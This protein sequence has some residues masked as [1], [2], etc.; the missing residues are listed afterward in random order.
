MDY[1]QQIQELANVARHYQ[2]FLTMDSGPDPIRGKM[3]GNLYDP[4]RSQMVSYREGLLTQFMDIPA[5]ALDWS[6]TRWCLHR[7]DSMGFTMDLLKKDQILFPS[8]EDSGEAL[9][10]ILSIFTEV[11]ED[12]LRSR[13]FYRHRDPDDFFHTL[14][15][16]SCHA[17]LSMGNMFFLGPSTSTYPNM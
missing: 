13:I 7:S 17:H 14:T 10:D 16:I 3:L 8:W 2:P 9:Q 5:N 6:Q 15:W 4:S 12:N 11:T 1:E